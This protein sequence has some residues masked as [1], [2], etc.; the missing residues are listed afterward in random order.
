MDFEKR[1]GR[2]Y[3]L[4]NKV[5]PGMPECPVLPRDEDKQSLPHDDDDNGL[6]MFLL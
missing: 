5:V 2:F 3:D 4:F 6:M 1:C